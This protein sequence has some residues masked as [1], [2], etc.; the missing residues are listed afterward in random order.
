MFKDNY[1]PNEK[2]PT[3]AQMKALAEAQAT[4]EN[5]TTNLETQ[6][7]LG[8][9]FF[10]A[11]QMQEALVAFEQ[12]KAHHPTSTLVFYW[13]GRVYERLGPVQAALEAHEHALLLDP[14]NIGSYVGLGILYFDQLHD[15]EAARHAF[16]TGLQHHPEDAFAVALLGVTYAHMGQFEEA[17]TSLQQAL[18]IHPENLFALGNLSILYLHQKQ[19]TDMMVTCHREI[20]IADGN[21]PRRL[22]GYVYTHQGSLG[23]A[24]EAFEKALTLSPQDYEARGALAQV[25]KKVG[26]YHEAETELALAREGALQDKEYGLACLEAVCGNFAQALTFL[27]GALQKSQVQ[28]GWARIDP[29]FAFMTDHPR[30]NALFQD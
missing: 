7:G 23:K 4:L 2:Q 27:E 21:D 16:Q 3:E 11:G 6:V 14:T 20:A 12:A 26:R 5:K 28:P 24:I 22:L 18:Q 9:A 13:L 1:L 17:I 29:E 19:Y 15:Y 30:F 10:N 25:Y 8:E